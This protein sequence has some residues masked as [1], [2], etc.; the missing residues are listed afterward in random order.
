MVRI[1]LYATGC[2]ATL[3]T[4]TDITKVRHILDAKRVQYEEVRSVLGCTGSSKSCGRTA[5]Q[6]TQ[7][8]H[9]EGHHHCWHLSHSPRSW[10]APAT[11]CP[12]GGARPLPQVDLWLDPHRR[13]E[14]LRNSDGVTKLPQ[15][16]VDSKY[17]GAL[18][19][20]PCRRRG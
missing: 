17:I 16:H 5:D 14:M 12:D 2:P 6:H 20:A 15:L 1:V 11:P 18:S 19:I 10:A 9:K 4:K 8:M 13:A 7:P 3:K